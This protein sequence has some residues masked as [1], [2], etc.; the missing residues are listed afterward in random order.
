MSFTKQPMADDAINAILIDCQIATKTKTFFEKF[1]V[2]M[3]DYLDTP[4][5]I[6]ELFYLFIIIIIAKI[7]ESIAHKR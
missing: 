1:I 2:A 7:N 4:I 6:L 3:L 5:P